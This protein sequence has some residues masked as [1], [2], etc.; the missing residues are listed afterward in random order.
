LEN[1][2]WAEFEA[3]AVKNKMINFP[4]LMTKL[5]GESS[6]GRSFSY[7]YRDGY[8]PPGFDVC[9]RKLNDEGDPY[10]PLLALAPARPP[11]TGPYLPD[12]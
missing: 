5:R 4:P 11:E 6:I 3:Y 2:H 12:K 10:I 1:R 7:H 8:V 9:S